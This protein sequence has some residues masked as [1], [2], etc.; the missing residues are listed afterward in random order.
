MPRYV[1]FLRALN[2]GGHHIVKMEALRDLFSDLG[3]AGVET[4]IASGNVIFE[5]KS[6]AAG[7]LE[8]KIEAHLA[9]VLGHSVSVFLRTTGDLQAI[10]AH[11]PFAAAALQSARALNIGF[12]KEA[13]SP[14]AVA[15]VMALATPIDEFHVHGR[16]LYWLCRNKQSES[17]FS[18]QQFERAIKG[19]AT[20]RNATTI[21]KLASKYCA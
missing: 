4:F 13:L 21:A 10:S 7:Q 17:T 11:R 6:A 9:G 1:A 5:A 18:N 3:F 8:K 16:E 14:A 2:V 15:A 19:V 20:L 12:Y